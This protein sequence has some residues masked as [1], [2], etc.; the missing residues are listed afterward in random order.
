MKL[1]QLIR[2]LPSEQLS[3]MQTLMHNMQAGFDV[4]KEM[5]EFER[6]LPPGFRE[7]M[8]SIMASAGVPAASSDAAAASAPASA[9]AFESPEPRGEMGL[10]DARLTVLRGVAAGEIAPEDAER[11]RFPETH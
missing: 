1:S 4:R 8:M 3:K 2:E 11:L 6:A 10:R 7:R 9:E 5:E